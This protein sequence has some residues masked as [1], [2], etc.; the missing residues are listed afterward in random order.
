MRYRVGERDARIAATFRAAGVLFA[1]GVLLAAIVFFA[2]ALFVPVAI[3]AGPAFAALPTTFNATA[4]RIG[5]F[6]AAVS[7]PSPLCTS[8]SRRVLPPGRH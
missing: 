7:I 2:A 3:T 6:N 4:A 8:I 5:A 1:A